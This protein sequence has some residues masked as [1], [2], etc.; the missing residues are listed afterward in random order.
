MTLLVCLGAVL[1]LLLFIESAAKILWFGLSGILC[2]CTGVYMFSRGLFL[3]W[4]KEKSGI[5]A[6]PSL[7]DPFRSYA[8]SDTKSDS[9]DGLRPSQQISAKYHLP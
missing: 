1:F 2:L 8:R 6:H 5:A 4:H 3:G 9:I 7:A